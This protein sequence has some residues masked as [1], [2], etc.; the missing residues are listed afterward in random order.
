LDAAV[1]ANYS[2]EVSFG[3]N[4]PDESPFNFTISGIVTNQLNLTIAAS[5]ASTV[6]PGD[7]YTYALNYTALASVSNTQVSLTLPGHTTFISSD[8]SCTVA[9][10][11][12]TCDLGTLSAGTGS[13]NFVVLVD[14]L[15]KVGTPLTLAT[16]SYSIRGTG[17]AAVNGS[18]SV[19]A[20][21]ETPFADV[22]AGYWALD[23]V[24]SIWAAGITTG[25]LSSPLSYCPDSDI[26][27]AEM[28]VYVERGIHGSSYT[29][30]VVPL[31][32]VD[33]AGPYQYWIEA[34]RADG[35]TGGCGGANFCPNASITRA[36]MA[37]FLL[38]AKYGSSYIPP[39]PTGT[40]WLDVPVTH[41][42]AAWAEQLGIEGISAGC[43]GGKFCPEEPVTRAE[44]A[45]L[46]Q[47]TFSLPLPS[48]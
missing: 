41:W 47:R 7:P 38:R 25:C 22:P 45:V 36:Q 19:T 34:L 15:K 10:G 21:V 17:V 27:R 12:A 42:A 3:N 43:G 31:T 14:K 26:S 39:A 2:G 48:P 37:I 35:I 6:K 20:N 4:D 5:G 11:I 23:H 18:A 8:Q 40:V 9:G 46:V 44:M 1:A 16:T 24:Q 28:A 29:P 13:F 30:P 33:T 32:F